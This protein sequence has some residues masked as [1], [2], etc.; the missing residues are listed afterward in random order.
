MIP[1][2]PAAHW[3]HILQHLVFQEKRGKDDEEQVADNLGRK[4]FDSCHNI[5]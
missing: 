4:L 3:Y 5:I 1:T 2:F